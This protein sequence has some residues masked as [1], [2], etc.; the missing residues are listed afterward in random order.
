MCLVPT[1]WYP[2]Y[3]PVASGA[4]S[5]LA[6]VLVDTSVTKMG[7]VLVCRVQQPATP[8]LVMLLWGWSAPASSPALNRIAKGAILHNISLSY[9]GSIYRQTIEIRHQGY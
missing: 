4:L 7:C 1:T 8:Q 9:A 5:D 2:N 6:L 3:L